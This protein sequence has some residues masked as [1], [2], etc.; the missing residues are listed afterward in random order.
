MGVFHEEQA[1]AI[2]HMDGPMLVLAGPGS[3]KT[4]VI[5]YRTK[6]L[7]EHWKVN[8]DRILVVTFTNAAAR[9]MKERFN[10]MT[11]GS[12]S[13]V[14]FGTFHSIFFGIL[15]WAYGFTGDNILREEEKKAILKDICSKMELD[16]E[17]AG[18]FYQ[19]L[20][21]E[22]SLVKGSLV[23]LDYYYSTT[24]S[25]EVFQKIM[26]EYDNRLQ[27]MNKIDFDDMLTLTYELFQKRPDLLKKW[28]DKFQYI[29]IDEFQDINKAQYEVIKKL[30]APKNNLFIVGDDDQ[31]IYRFRGAKPEIMLGFEKDFPGTKKV[32]LGINYRSTG[33]I[34]DASGRIIEHN[35]RRFPKE[36][37]SNRDEGEEVKIEKVEDQKGQNDK[38]LALIRGYHSKG[39]PYGNMAV[40]YR[41]N[42][43]PRP[44]IGKLMEYNVPFQV[45]DT[46]P[47]LFDHWIG[48]NMIAYLKM[49]LGDRNRQT[50]LSIMNRPKRYISR[51][52]VSK[53][54]VNLVELADEVKEKPWVSQRIEKLL[55][56]LNR[57]A[58]MTPYDAISYLRT[59][60]GYDDY[61]KEYASFRK[62]KEEELFDIL[63]EI[64]DTAKGYQKIEDWFFYIEEYEEELREQL[65]AG[66][67]KAED[68]VV[69]TTMH[70]AKGLEYDVV[71]LIDAN[72]G[73]IPHKKALKDA[74]LEEERRL[75]YVAVTRAK[76]Y[77]HIFVPKQL[78]QKE[79]KISRFVKEMG[80][81]TSR[82]KPGT[83]IIHKKYG[84]GT[85][86]STDEQRLMIQ[87]DR[88]KGERR[89]SIAFALEHDLIRLE[90]K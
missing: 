35:K 65:R 29:L 76:E 82:L 88:L 71:F 11:N 49:A 50:F 5:T 47:S 46:I 39:I 6:Y 36:I 7:I 17:E 37:T 73:I 18:D 80:I 81:E 55:L 8:P 59:Q 51:N 56:D 85:I 13:G 33:Q 63:I 64:A 43:Q 38:I 84:S 78:Y 19:S 34:V 75:F 54:L 87:F 57:M 25:D 69:F 42:T 45:R 9:E 70:S 77:L 31:S 28:Q 15:R 1:R 68:S 44:L 12:C 58:K 27:Q 41:T 90:Q 53:P 61:L 40:I 48:R 24:C 4:L 20:I 66:Q 3:G 23:N 74:D 52:L 21:G 67:K 83:R 86:L 79:M 72:E 10:R 26:G 2:R 32:L 30:A 16:M 14:T 62:M 22:I 60:V 89:I